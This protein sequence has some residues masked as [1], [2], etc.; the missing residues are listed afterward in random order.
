MVFFGGGSRDGRNAYAFHYRI[1]AGSMKNAAVAERVSVLGIPQS[2]GGLAQQLNRNMPFDP[3]RHTGRLSRL[4]PENYRGRAFVHWSMAIEQRATGWLDPLH[5]AKLREGLCHA[6]GRYGVLC[7]A[8]CLMP[9]HA[10]FLWVGWCESSDQKRA[11]ALFRGAWN[12]ELGRGGHELQRQAYDK[13][14]GEEQ[15]DHGAFVAVAHYVLAN[16]SRAGLAEDWRAYPF[17]G[18]LVPGYPNMDPRDDDFWERF[19]RIYER[20]SEEV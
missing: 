18:A 5:H 3:K 7:P 15:R 14:S 1:M 12:R 20:V 6:L 9:D 13:V 16:P 8:Y 4:A 2:C 17:I 11:M 10:H 19:W